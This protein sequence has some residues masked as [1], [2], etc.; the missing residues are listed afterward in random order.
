MRVLYITGEFPPMRGS[1]GDH[2][3][4]L[5]T[6]VMA[7]GHEVGVLTSTEARGA[8]LPGAEIFPLVEQWNLGSWRAIG[9]AA[10]GYDVLHL[11]YQAGAFGMGLAPQLM[12]DAT[13]LFTGGKPFVTTFHDLLLP[14]LFP[15]AGRARGWSVRHLAR[16]SD[17]VVVTNEEDA[18]AL[19]QQGVT[20]LWQIPIASPLPL[21]PGP[22]F[23]REAWRES[24]NVGLQ[25]KL[26]VH[27][28]FINRAKGVETLL[29]AYDGLLRAGQPVR[30][31]MA[32]DPL[33]ASDPSNKAYLE[34]IH[35]LAGE[36][37]LE[38]P[39]I[40]WTGD[41][42]EQELIRSILAADLIVLPFR[43]GAS[44]RRSTLVMSLSLGRP[45]VTTEPATPIPFLQNGHNIALVRRDDS[46]AFARQIA[47]LIR[48]EPTLRRLERG[49]SELRQHFDW[50]RIAEQY[51]EV[52]RAVLARR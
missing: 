44:L 34:E 9:E 7:Q 50:G 28:G 42:S 15:K 47:L 48:Y 21:D 14:Y 6:A 49:A 30:L 23:D 4:R 31:L 46:A 26:L 3:A 2:T 1:I 13:R 38:E 18:E 51:V 17:G 20:R 41:L 24:W 36:L 19:R 8:K 33:G 5:A 40:Q 16:A 35:H 25:H 37:N 43:E 12:A 52:Y 11:E 10:R 27:F 32:G 39:W 45:V 22:D 29:R